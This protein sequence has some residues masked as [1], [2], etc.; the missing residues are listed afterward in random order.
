MT[1]K[2]FRYHYYYFRVLRITCIRPKLFIIGSIN[3]TARYFETDRLMRKIIEEK[4]NF[5]AL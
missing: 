3:V 2:F 5:Y 1:V 4:K